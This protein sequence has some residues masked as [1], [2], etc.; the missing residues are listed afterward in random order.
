LSTFLQVRDSLVQDALQFG[1]HNLIC[2]VREGGFELLE[3]T[4]ECGD[5]VLGGPIH[6]FRI[7]VPS[8]MLDVVERRPE[9][10]RGW[11]AVSPKSTLGSTCWPQ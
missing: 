7:S 5:E 2:I 10:H 9:E 8:S 6:I 11:V 1:K 4:A 3:G